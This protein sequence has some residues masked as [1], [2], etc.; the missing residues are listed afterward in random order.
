MQETKHADSRPRG[1]PPT[2]TPTSLSGT[3]FRAN[4]AQAQ[5][6]DE[7]RERIKQQERIQKQEDD[8]NQEL[9][10]RNVPYKAFVD[11]LSLPS[12]IGTAIAAGAAFTILS[13]DSILGD[14]SPPALAQRREIVII[15]AWSAGLFAIATAIT[16]CL[17]A[18]YTSPSFCKSLSRKLNYRPELR[19]KFQPWPEWDFMRYVVAY[20]AVVGA[21]L[22]L[23]LHLTA[24]TLIIEIFKPYAPALVAQLIMVLVFILGIFG[25]TISVALEQPEARKR[26]RKFLRLPDPEQDPL[27]KQ[28]I[29]QSHQAEP[30]TLDEISSSR[31]RNAST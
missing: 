20:T 1:P 6:G 9:G 30:K 7:I 29:V 16:I 23:V 21:Y 18:L 15:L 27:H 12:T 26:W 10:Y 28:T 24:T 25:W 17:Q 22:A 14:D 31:A 5:E 4:S 2:R 8:E 13:A 11:A 3:L 19:E